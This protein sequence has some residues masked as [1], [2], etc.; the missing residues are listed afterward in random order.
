MIQSFRKLIAST[1][2]SFTTG[3]LTIAT[4]FLL[5]ALAFTGFKIFRANRLRLAQENKI[6]AVVNNSVIRAKEV[7]LLD[8]P[9]S[10][11][12]ALSLLVDF[13]LLDQEAARKHVTV[14]DD[15]LEKL[16]QQVILNTGTHTYAAAAQKLGRSTSGLDLQLKHVALLKKLADLKVGGNPSDM[17]HARGI[18]VKYE[19]PHGRTDAAALAY[20][21]SLQSQ[22]AQG[23]DIATLAK[24]YS[25][26]SLSG[27]TGGD[28]GTISSAGAP[29]MVRQTLDFHMQLA[30]SHQLGHSKAGM[31]L[32]GPVRGDVGYWIL[33]VVSTQ[34]EPR[35]DQSLYDREI[36][37]YRS[38]WD[39]KF[40]PM[41]MMQLRSAAYIEPPLAS[42]VTA[43]RT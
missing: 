26:D 7:S 1:R 2:L 15:E 38:E 21:R 9:T 24:K 23:A 12:E 41:V 33:Q 20:A 16:R 8:P 5:V 17:F 29:N 25:D 43:K 4:L 40:E 28:L 11:D 42:P 39:G 14:G 27:P 35:S 32:T 36:A 31:I 10:Y 13:T 19:G 30:L 3:L 22:I 6:V 34:S 37:L 18:L